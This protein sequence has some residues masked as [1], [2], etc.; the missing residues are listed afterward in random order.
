MTREEYMARRMELQLA[1][2]KSREEERM[3]LHTVENDKVLAYRNAADKIKCFKDSV[4]NELRESLHRLALLSD[5]LHRKH[6]VRRAEID[7][8]I[9]VLDAEMKRMYY[10]SLKEGGQV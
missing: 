9:K 7:A 1:I 6:A 5:N 2:T 10:V 3:D 4:E 8:D